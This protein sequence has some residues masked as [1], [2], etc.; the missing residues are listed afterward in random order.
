MWPLTSPIIETEFRRI[1]SVD[2]VTVLYGGGT[3]SCG[4]QTTA[5]CYRLRDDGYGLIDVHCIGNLALA[6]CKCGRL[7][8]IYQVFITYT[9][10]LPTGT[11][12][13][14][15]SLHLSL[16]MIAEEALNEICD[17]GANPGGP[18]APGVTG[19]SSLGYNEQLNPLSLKMTAMGASARMNK[20][21]RFIRHL[22]LKR[23]LR[24]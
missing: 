13:D 6:A 17:P 14:D 20:A 19:Y 24:M 5:G 18:G 9:A 8:N 16:S 2:E 1:R 23:P 11:A 15:T 12:A 10:G 21:R 4:L 22:I 7:S 3:G